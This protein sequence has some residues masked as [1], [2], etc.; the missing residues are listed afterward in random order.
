MPDAV[1]VYRKALVDDGVIDWARLIAMM[2]VEPAALVGLEHLGRITKGGIADLT[3]IDPDLE[4]TISA[5]DFLTTG[6]NCPFEGWKVTGRAIS[7]IVAG[8]PRWSLQGD[9]RLTMATGH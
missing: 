9:S 6:R 4:W 5:D 3:I 2:T 8:K 7:S 1:D